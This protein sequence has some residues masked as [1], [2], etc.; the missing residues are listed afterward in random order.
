MLRIYSNVRPTRQTATC[1]FITIIITFCII[2]EV[3]TVV[4]K[5]I[6]WKRFKK[7]SSSEYCQNLRNK[8]TF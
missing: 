7:V 2:S 8:D 3:W 6:H 1:R 5:Q 4:T